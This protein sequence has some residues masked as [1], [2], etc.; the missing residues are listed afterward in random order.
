M[1]GVI[2]AAGRGK[3]LASMGFDKPKCLLPFGDWTLLDN[4]IASLTDNGIDRLAVV[5]GYRQELVLEAVKKHPVHID[6]VVNSDYAQTNTINSLYL[7]REYLGED[8]V[9]FNADVLFDR[10]IIERLLSERDSALAIEVGRCAEEEVKVIVDD[11]RRIARIG[12]ELRP[13]DCLG[14]FVGIGVFRA[15]VN[16]DL[17]DALCY[18]N[19]E[20]QERN[21]F[22]EA[23]VERICDRHVI[24]AVD[25]D[26]YRAIE[27]DTPEDFEAA[28]V[29]A[30]TI[31]RSR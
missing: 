7:A 3:R 30:D 12:K 13:A 17:V 16:G 22:F 1:I 28:R 23:A 2:L 10:R 29:L 21:L 4:I 20:L 18:F 15:E 8:F 9:Y 5:V 14:E 27:I 26:P 31:F 24:R 11:E 6:V 19:E 25:I